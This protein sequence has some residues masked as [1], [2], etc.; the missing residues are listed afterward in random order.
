MESLFSY[1]A[2][3]SPCNYLPEQRA[4]LEYEMVQDLSGPD[5]ME[6]MLAGWRR[7]GGMM[8]RPRC[9]VCSQCRALRVDV[10]RFAPNRSQRRAW[11]GTTEKSKCASAHRALRGLNFGCTTS[12]TP[13]R[14]M[15]RAGPSIPPR[16]SRAMRNRS[17]TI[18]R[19]RKNGTFIW[20]IACWAWAMSIDCRAGCRRFIF[21]T[22]RA[23]AGAAWERSMC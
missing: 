21:T 3:P 1:L 8:F 9:P 15:P 23:S 2:P 13:F 4:S 20:A 7:F 22:I 14:S 12:T 10:A 19:S 16:I 11:R 17:S 5:Y 18:R 6:R